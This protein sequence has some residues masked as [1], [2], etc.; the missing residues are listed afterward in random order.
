MMS[1]SPTRAHDKGHNNADGLR[2]SHPQQ[3]VGCTGIVVWKFPCIV[4]IITAD[5]QLVRSRL[6]PVH[7]E[8]RTRGSTNHKPTKTAN[9]NAAPSGTMV[10][11]SIT[12]PTKIG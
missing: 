12:R 1:S 11:S 9:R 3:P 10:P 7:F 2:Q 4:Q 6:E 5:R 8:L